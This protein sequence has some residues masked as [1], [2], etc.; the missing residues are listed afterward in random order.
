[1]GVYTLKGINH[2]PEIALAVKAFKTLEFEVG[3][4][5]LPEED[6]RLENEV[7]LLLKLLGEREAGVVTFPEPE[8][9]RSKEILESEK[10]LLDRTRAL[11]LILSGKKLILLTTLPS[12]CYGVPPRESFEK[13]WV[14]LKVGAQVDMDD[15]TAKL[16][17]SGYERDGIV[18]RKGC[19]AKR[20]GILDIFPPDREKPVRLEFFGDEVVDIREFDPET[21]RST[22]RIQ[23]LKLLIEPRSKGNS[24]IFDFLK[25][26]KVGFFF[27]DPLISL[28]RAEG[29]IKR[30]DLPLD[31]EKILEVAS[32]TL[33]TYLIGAG[34]SSWDGDELVLPVEGL[35]KRGELP[36]FLMEKSS[37]GYTTVVVSPNEL[38]VKKMLLFL[39]KKGIAAKGILGELSRGFSLPEEKLIFLGFK[40]IFGHNIRTQPRPRKSS[41]IDYRTLKEGEPVVHYDHGIGIYRGIK[42]LDAG[43]TKADFVVLEY[44]QGDMLYV[45]VYHLEKLQRF[46]GERENLKIDRLGSKRWLT[47]KK[48]TKES[49]RKILRELVELYAS[50][51]VVE[52]YRFSIPEEEYYSFVS[53]FPFEE[54]PDQERAI[55]DVLSDMM[56][57]SPMDRIICGDVGFGKTEVAMRAAFI[58]TMNGKQVAILAPTT[59]LVEQHYL[60]FK[61]R[62]KNYPVVIEMLSRFRSKS[63]QKK[64][65][66][67]LKKGSIDIVIGTHR[68]LQ[69]D[70][71]FKDLGLLIIDEEQRFGVKAKE[72]IREMKKNVDTL[73]LTATPIPRTLQHALSGL[74][75][76]SLI[77]TPP[78]ERK[79]IKTII[80][81]FDENLIKDAITF[82]LNRGGQV[83][84]VHNNIETIHSI[85][86]LLERLVPKAKIGVAHGKMKEKE[87]ESVMISF[88]K[89][90]LDVLVSTTIVENGL[91]VPKA[92]TMI[93]NR[94]DTFG[95]A[96]LYQLRGRIG[97]SGTKAYA[98]L[99]IPRD[100]VMK[101]K[102]LERLKTLKEFEELG[103]G[104]HIAMKDLEMRGCGNLLGKAQWGKI[105]ELGIE[106]YLKMLEEVVEEIK[107]KKL[108]EEVAATI[109]LGIPSYIPDSYIQDPTDKFEVYKRLSSASSEDE[110][111]NILKELRDRFGPVPEEVLALSETV[112]MKITAKK[113]MVESII[114]KGKEIII[115]FHEKT[116]VNPE[117]IMRFVSENSSTWKI[118]DA[119]SLSMFMENPM[120]LAD[121][122][123]ELERFAKFTL[124]S[125]ELSLASSQ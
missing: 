89:G 21:Q 117:A 82:E 123:K 2:P 33:P 103:S 39:K 98:Y 32:E 58:A 81:R 12:I 106:M 109:D 35:P 66:E 83:Y 7:S 13:G 94:A 93:I 29:T 90:E 107:G 47:L 48:K 36:S 5:V 75:K 30:D 52:G 53:S 122:R 38:F 25:G 44:A 50:R 116:P 102:A 112:K 119:Y 71:E 49:L 57:A 27:V 92:N 118:R 70:V 9:V 15:L 96:Q 99:I 23:H 8:S 69:D 77:L 64:V 124:E 26:K 60:N 55:E 10:V 68:L 84:F 104:Y 80:A 110:V 97:R 17:S 56:E 72:K 42:T 78:P 115:K 34:L 67:G 43:K 24:T 62:F 63:E 28:S 37:M 65:I 51:K 87:L 111:T 6:P 45:P 125:R 95:L 101:E 61:E 14:E 54:T 73:T 120:T 86:E 41:I 16:S 59:I 121:I 114:R 74:K 11:S 18:V 19:F 40:D 100:E 113:L 108:Q 85:K 1:M 76:M 88:F 46:T 4:V 105:N 20:G 91:D 22:S 3:I 31:S 79:S